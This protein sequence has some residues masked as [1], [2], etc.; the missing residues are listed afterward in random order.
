MTQSA[1]STILARQGKGDRLNDFGKKR[2]GTAF[3]SSNSS[4]WPTLV[5][6]V[7]NSTIESQIKIPHRK[8]F[9]KTDKNITASSVIICLSKYFHDIPN[10]TELQRRISLC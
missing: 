4:D 1:K 7:D 6:K 5:V 10:S 8:V 9:Q 3:M 2:G